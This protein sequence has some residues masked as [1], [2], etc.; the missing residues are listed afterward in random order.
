MFQFDK[1]E[2]ERMKEIANYVSSQV[3]YIGNPD[4]SNYLLETAAEYNTYFEIF[5]KFIYQKSEKDMQKLVDELLEVLSNLHNFIDKNY[6]DKQKIAESIFEKYAKLS[7]GIQNHHLIAV[8]LSALED[9]KKEEKNSE[10]QKEV[11]DS[12]QLALLDQ[13]EKESKNE[14]EKDAEKAEKIERLPLETNSDE[15]LSSNSLE[16]ENEPDETGPCR[17]GWTFY[18]GTNSC[19]KKLPDL[20]YWPDA[21]K[22]CENEGAF[23]A[24]IMDE[25][26]NRFAADLTRID[27]SKDIGFVGQV[28]LGGKRGSID[29]SW[30]YYTDGSGVQYF[31][32]TNG[33]PND[34]EK[35]ED[36][37]QLV[38]NPTG[39]FHYDPGYMW[40][41]VYCDQN[42]YVNYPLCKYFAS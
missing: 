10:L 38:A 37:L 35:S 12:E 17:K 25:A 15:K 6:A 28:W 41:D 7:R 14:E 11:L 20:V 32:W 18:N 9:Y 3:D 5:N 33:V 40:N 36:C 8:Y 4:T 31:A 1:T 19:F 30:W 26:E 29:R 16:E 21:V 23:L 22:L 2:E 13:Y 39:Y 42:G 24:S 34:V 27:T